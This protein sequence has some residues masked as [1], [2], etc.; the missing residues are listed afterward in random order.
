MREWSI[1]NDVY[2]SEYEA[3]DDFECVFEI[4]KR[5]TMSKNN[6]EIRYERLFK[7]KK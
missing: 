3:P 5:M 1:H 4:P 2:V 7:L 6:S